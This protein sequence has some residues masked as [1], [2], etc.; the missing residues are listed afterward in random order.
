MAF[1]SNAQRIFS[2]VC[3]FSLICTIGVS[4]ISCSHHGN[5]DPS[6]T[7]NPSTQITTQPT[8]PSV[9]LEDGL[10]AVF[11]SIFAKP[12]WAALYAQAGVTDSPFEDAQDYA[13]YMQQLVGQNALTYVKNG[14]GC[15]VCA[16][17]RIVGGLTVVQAGSDWVLETLT[18]KLDRNVSCNILTH[19]DNTVTVNGVTLDDSYIVKT[20]TTAGDAYLPEG[21]HGYQSV[22][23]RVSGLFAAPQVS[24]TDG[25]AEVTMEYDAESCTY[26]QSYAPEVLTDAEK[27][28]LATAGKI[29]CRSMIGNVSFSTAQQY[30]DYTSNVYKVMTTI[31]TWMQNYISYRFEEPSFSEVHHYSDTLYSARVKMSMFVTRTDGTEKEYPFHSTM[32]MKLKNSKWIVDEMVNLSFDQP[33]VTVRLSFVQDGQV[34]ETQ[35]VDASAATVTPPAIEVPEGMYLGW[36][37]E[38]SDTPLLIPDAAGV[39]AVPYGTDL[40]PMTLTAKIVSEQPAVDAEQ[41]WAG[42]DDGIR[43]EHLAG[44]T[45]VAHVMII[46]DP[47][48]VYMATSTESFS[49][50]IPGLR[51]TEAIEKEGAIAAINAG[52]FYDNGTSQLVVGS[53]PEGLVVANGK[54]VWNRR[55]M[56]MP[57]NGFVG[58]DQNNKL[59]VAHSM[60]A[61]KAMELQIRD[62]CCFGP[63]LIMD[64]EVNQ[65][66]YT[67]AEH[68]NPRTAIGQR[69]DGAVIFLCI[70]GRMASSLGG[71]YKDIIDIMLRYGAVNAC[72]LDGGSSTVMLYR[73]P[74]DGQVDMVN[75]YSVL[76]AQPRR[77]PNF[78][79]VKPS[80]EN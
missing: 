51:I 22:E 44:D 47:S 49:K 23:Y 6:V 57:E 66:I 65:S 27:E 25:E 45:Y 32:L 34:L 40:Q 7:T 19:P 24:V 74:A 70:E 46:R 50:N 80:K 4:L 38:G 59:I 42:H 21:V 60:T 73:D 78:F 48:Q 31:S 67:A 41:E 68:F 55:E 75:T 14:N 3:A 26:S 35:M 61:D 29:Y 9:P 37:I 56:G 15:D 13:A 58:L 16:G 72:N 76:Q 17:D 77:M 30:I 28:A 11:S 64:S 36:Y 63:A 52:A 10:N 8:G 69:A 53:V 33:A 54:V 39:C 18:L 62:G 79:M 1:S 43:I 20:V 2:R 71:S 12:D 5:N